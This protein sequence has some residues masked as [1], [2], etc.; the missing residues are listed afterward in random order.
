MFYCITILIH[1]QAPET[2]AAPHPEPE[3][4][5]N[6]VSQDPRYAKFFK[7]L[8]MVRKIMCNWNQSVHKWGSATGEN[9]CLLYLRKTLKGEIN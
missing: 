5:S 3:P 4:E 2:E 1:H 8:K 9:A 7:M 6:P